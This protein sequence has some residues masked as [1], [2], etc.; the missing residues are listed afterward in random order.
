MKIE[1]FKNLVREIVRK[2][3]AEM[4]KSKSSTEE[5]C[6]GEGCLDEKSVPQPYD[7]KGAR[8]MT[9]AQIAK[10]KRIGKAM[11]DDEEKVSKFRKAHGDDWRSYLWAAATSATFREKGSSKSDDKKKK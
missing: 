1:E 6:E 3:L 9:K 7:R 5:I 8:R 11:E 2:E 10:R 4:A